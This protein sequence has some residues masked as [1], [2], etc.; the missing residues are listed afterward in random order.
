MASGSINDSTVDTILS[1][2]SDVATTDGTSLWE[3]PPAV[4][5]RPSGKRGCHGGNS[6]F[7]AR[8]AQISNGQLYIS[9]DTGALTGVGTVGTGLPTSGTQT[10]TGARPDRRNFPGFS[11]DDYFFATKPGDTSPDTLYVPNAVRDPEFSGWWF[12]DAR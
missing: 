12:L 4:S 9:A 6:T 5:S 11:P 10:V 3:E 7:T 2:H 1:H 8:V